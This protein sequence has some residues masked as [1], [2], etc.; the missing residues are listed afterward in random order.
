MADTQSYSH[1]FRANGIAALVRAGTA[2]IPC[3]L[4]ELSADGAFLR[5]A[6]SVAVGTV[7]EVDLKRGAG[8]SLH[9][10][11]VVLRQIPGRDGQQI[12]LDVEFR[13]VAP[14]DLQRLI[15]WLDEMKGRPAAEPIPIVVEAPITAPV[16]V[17]TSPIA[18]APIGGRVEDDRSKLMLQIKGLFR[19]MEELRHRLRERELEVDDLRRR[20]STAEQLLGSRRAGK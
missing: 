5:A 3:Q 17:R 9:L 20:L 6:R 18:T 14:A 2:A 4:E 1:R 8:K 12:G 10:R 15:S 13:L 11:A 16:P 7:L 19:E